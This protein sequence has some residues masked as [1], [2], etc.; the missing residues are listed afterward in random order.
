M[1]MVTSS[2]NGN[3]GSVPGS[4]GEVPTKSAP[5]SRPIDR[6]PGAGH[7]SINTGA[8]VRSAG[9]FEGAGDNIDRF[10][11]R[12]QKILPRPP[13]VDGQADETWNQFSGDY[14]QGTSTFLEGV[15]CLGQAVRS[16]V[17]SLVQF[18]QYCQ[19]TEDNAVSI[20]KHAVDS[21]DPPP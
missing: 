15:R 2:F 8:I 3:P 17:E 12:Q 6:G 13:L 9:Q 1:T 5:G 21:D 7:I 19:A 18:A 10:A 20:A 14:E 4:G 16:L 11:S